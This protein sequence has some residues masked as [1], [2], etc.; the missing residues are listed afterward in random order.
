MNQNIRLIARVDA[1]GII[2]YV[3][4]EYL[5]WL[6]YSSNELAGQPT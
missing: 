5:E 6:G 4:N 3:N 1:Q 2:Q